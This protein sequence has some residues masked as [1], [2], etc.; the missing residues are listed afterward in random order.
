MIFWIIV[1]E[2]TWT[3]GGELIKRIPEIK[4]NSEV[5]WI[6]EG[7]GDNFKVLCALLKGNA[8]PTK[9]LN[10]DSDGK[11]REKKITKD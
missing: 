3:K 9:I 6:E 4:T 5:K 8:I 1:D 7:V 10:L 2:E 11:R